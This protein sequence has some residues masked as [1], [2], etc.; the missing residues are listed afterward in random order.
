MCYPH[1]LHKSDILDILFDFHFMFFQ[2]FLDCL[3]PDFDKLC[4]FKWYQRE[5][6]GQPLKSHLLIIDTAHN[7][8]E[9]LVVKVH[10]CDLWHQFCKLLI[11]ASLKVENFG[12]QCLHWD[13]MAIGDDAVKS[14]TQ[15]I[16]VPVHVAPFYGHQWQ[17]CCKWVH[18]LYFGYVFVS[19]PWSSC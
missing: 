6:K 4:N 1:G 9:L 10:I 5:I 17:F 14:T 2:T 8:Y 18:C 19:W 12:D 11:V 3:K 15:N 16:N 7:L 13:L